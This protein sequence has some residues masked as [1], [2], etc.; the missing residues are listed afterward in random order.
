MI[1]IEREIFERARRAL[2]SAWIG[3]PVSRI[4]WFDIDVIIIIH[5][6]IQ[7]AMKDTPRM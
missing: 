7:R 2:S 3:I 6:D 5:I 4:V 1:L